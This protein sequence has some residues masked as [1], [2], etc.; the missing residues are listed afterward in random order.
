MEHAMTPA[1]CVHALPGRL[2]VKVVAIKNSPAAAAAVERALCQQRGV[3]DAVA[4]PVTGSVLIRYDAERIAPQTVLA[5]LGL[6]EPPLTPAS[7]PGSAPGPS[8]PLTKT[9]VRLVLAEMLSLGPADILFA[10]IREMTS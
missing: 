6:F 8:A 4:N 9:L 7:A 5:C 1:R 2:R 3:A 10:L